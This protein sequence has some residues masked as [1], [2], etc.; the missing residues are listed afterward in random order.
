MTPMKGGGGREDLKGM[1]ALFAS[2]ACALIA[3]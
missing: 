1:T 2:D 3:G